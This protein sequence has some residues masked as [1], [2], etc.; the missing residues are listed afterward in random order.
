R[1]P[2]A[3]RVRQCRRRGAGA[4]PQ[5]GDGLEYSR[6]RGEDERRA[7][8]PRSALD[9][10]AGTKDYLSR[11]PFSRAAQDQKP[12]HCLARHAAGAQGDGEG[13]L[14]GQAGAQLEHTNHKH[15]ETRTMANRT[16]ET[17]KIERDTGANAGLTWVI[18]N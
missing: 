7:G 9:P 13:K 8:S 18:L 11:L 10:R 16:Y 4:R 14:A 1:P 12:H 6:R 5:P 17:V 3:R 15:G 2:A